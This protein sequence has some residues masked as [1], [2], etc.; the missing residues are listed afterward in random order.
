MKTNIVIAVLTAGLLFFSACENFLAKKPKSD[1]VTPESIDDCQLLLDDYSTMNTGYPSDGQ[2]SSDDYYLSEAS[3]QSLSE[4]ARSTYTWNPLGDHDLP[5]WYYP[6]RVVY[7]ANLAL[8]TLAKIKPLP[9]EVYRYNHARGGALFFRSY[10]FYLTAEIFSL[11]YQPSG[12]NSAPAIPLRL[13][14]NV[15]EASVRATVQQTYDRIVGDLLEAAELLPE[16]TT[17]ASRPG[18]PAAYAALARVFL[19]MGRF[20]KAL[21]MA[22]KSLSVYS[23][24]L[25]Y[26][27]VDANAAIPFNR[28]N[29]EVLFQATSTMG[30]QF[31]SNRALI[32]EDLLSRYEAGDLRS[33]LFFNRNSDGTYVFRGNYD[34]GSGQPFFIGITT[35]E[36]YL[37]RAECHARL[38]HVAAAT[39]DLETL[40]NKR[41]ATDV[42][43][44]LTDREEVLKRVLEERRKELVFRGT[45]WSDL[46]R[47]NRE[48]AHKLTLRR[49]VGN[50][51]YMLSPDDARYALRIPLEVIEH[52][53]LAQNKR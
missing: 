7:N 39:E 29:E 2:A 13:T 37:I 32:G 38:G 16:K 14:P 49:T 25:D 9:S 28:F 47:L 8:Q 1:L 30:V 27:N 33:T 42:Q 20:E 22:D 11:P 6:Y 52:S 24:L 48:E 53:S 15:N 50:Q 41:Y 36:V 26:R 23:E 34:G 12:D 45:R 51:E 3:W 18:K 5:Q 44:G 35:P 19:S 17:V 4:N 46:R 31:G 43:L 21:E 10:A 40:L